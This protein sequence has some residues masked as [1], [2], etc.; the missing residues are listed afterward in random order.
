MSNCNS[1]YTMRSVGTG[2]V[3]LANRTP[4]VTTA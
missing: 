3:E 4:A 1:N 2:I